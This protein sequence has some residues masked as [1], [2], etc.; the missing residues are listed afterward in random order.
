MCREFYQ[1]DYAGV[2]FTENPSGAEGVYTEYAQGGG[3]QLVSG[4]IT[5]KGFTYKDDDANQLLD[6]IPFNVDKLI[7]AIKVL[8]KKFDCEIDVEW[9]ASGDNISIV[10]ARPITTTRK[11]EYW[12]NTNLNENYPN[13]I[14]PLL[15]S[16]AKDSYYHYFKN[17][18]KLLLIEKSSIKALEPEFQNTVG[19][20]GGRIYYNMTNIHKIMSSSPFSM[21]LISSFNDFVGY[22]EKGVTGEKPLKK[23]PTYKALGKMVLL[24]IQLPKYVR[25]IEKIVS[26]Y[27]SQVENN[28][29]D[30]QAN[31]DQFLNIRFN[32]WYRASLAD[33]FAMIHYKLLGSFA[34]KY[35]GNDHVGIHN[36]LVQ[37]IPDLI[38]GKPLIKLYS[39]T[40]LIKEVKGGEQYFLETVRCLT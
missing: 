8:K 23:T 35:F 20:W 39:I 28:L 34:R 25:Q 6:H 29:T 27:V 15:F 18:A 32:Q 17:L 16:V 14:S 38:S 33:F 21:Y 22:Q 24:N 36:A 9:L 30:L 3:E 5:P 7:G 26:D 37:Y 12:S 11:K 2:T 40:Q 10:Q 19:S 1:S 31:Y 4:K 13:P